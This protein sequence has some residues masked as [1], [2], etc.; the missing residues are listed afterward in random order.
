MALMDEPLLS[1]ELVAREGIAL[2]CRMVE[3][4]LAEELV[5]DG[6]LTLMH[7]VRA[8]PVELDGMHGLALLLCGCYMSLRPC[9]VELTCVLLGLAVH[10]LYSYG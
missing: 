5:T 1:A 8:G 10:E 9:M 7:E 4:A 3:H 6:L 2:P